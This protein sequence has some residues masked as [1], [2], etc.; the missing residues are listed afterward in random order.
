MLGTRE[1]VWETSVAELV[2]IFRSALSTIV[3]QL[4]R[5]RIP[6]GVRAGVDAWDEISESLFRHI[7]IEG[8]RSALPER[9]MEDFRTPQYEIDYEDYRDLSFIEAV[10]VAPQ[11]TDQRLVFHSFEIPESPS[12]EIENVKC[13]PVDERGVILG[14]QYVVVPIEAVAFR[15]AY[16]RPRK[17]KHLDKL[18]VVL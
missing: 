13:R 10:L 12:S 9:E 7:V 1:R 8:I 5:A 16:R 2:E 14:S 6:V 3:P 18:K 15:C 11:K 4:R 17:L